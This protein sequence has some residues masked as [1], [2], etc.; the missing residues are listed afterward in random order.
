MPSRKSKRCVSRFGKS[1]SVYNLVVVAI[2]RPLYGHI[3][4]CF[5]G[6]NDLAGSGIQAKGGTSDIV[7]RAN[8]F[9]SAGGRALN[10]GG[11]TGLEFFRPQPPGTVEAQ[12]LV[13]EGNK[14]IAANV[15][16]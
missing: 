1:S 16:R 7:I 2:D 3:S 12:N 11:S 10:L 6:N 4:R 5:Q 9:E 14:V 8:R 13:A 15:N